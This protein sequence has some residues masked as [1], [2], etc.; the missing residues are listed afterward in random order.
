MNDPSERNL[1]DYN[2]AEEIFL[3]NTEHQAC[4]EY[5]HKQAEYLK[6]LDFMNILT[7]KIRFYSVCR[8]KTNVN[9]K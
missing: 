7:E 3:S 6:A 4:K 1:D 2:K 5:G 9:S 8:A